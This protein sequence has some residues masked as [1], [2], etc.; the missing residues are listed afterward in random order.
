MTC[1]K[2]A[3]S[4]ELLGFFGFIEFVGKGKGIKLF[5]LIFKD[6]WKH[7]LILILGLIALWGCVSGIS[8]LH[9]Y[10]TPVATCARCHVSNEPSI[11]DLNSKIVA[12]ASKFCLSCHDKEQDT[13]GTNPPYVKN[14]PIILAGGDFAFAVKS[15]GNGH[16]IEEGD[17]VNTLKPP[18]GKRILDKFTCLSCHF[19]HN[20]GNYR[21]LRLEINEKSTVVKAEADKNYVK[22]R[23]ISGMNNFCTS[24]HPMCLTKPEAKEHWMNHPVE[25]EI[26]R[27]RPNIHITRVEGLDVDSG[28]KRVFCLSCHYAHA[29]PY[30]NAWLWD[31]EKSYTGCLECHDI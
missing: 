5:M 18:G 12:D 26:N 14:N 25:V 29:G 22:N 10:P 20:H 6:M 11:K 15:P 16:S 4:R 23:Y 8:T 3:E 7:S 24:C 13:S 9:E 21:N 30:P 17:P 19:L 2:R 27:S 31:Y 28:K 1:D